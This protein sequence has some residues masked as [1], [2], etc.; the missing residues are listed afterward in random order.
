MIKKTAL[1]AVLCLIMLGSCGTKNV[2]EI[3]ANMIGTWDIVSA[4]GKSTAGGDKAPYI[5]FAEGGKFN[6]NASVNNFFGEYKPSKNEPAIKN[7]G[8]TRMMGRSMDI[9]QNITDALNNTTTIKLQGDKA[10][11]YDKNGKEVMVLKKK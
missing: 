2:L 6:G 3:S 1:L 10:V 4:M 7:V 9:E 11:V 5:T 8:M